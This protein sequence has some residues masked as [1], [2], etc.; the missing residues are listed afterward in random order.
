VLVEG[1]MDFL[2]AW[3]DGVKN[4][5]ATSGTA[6]T[7]EHLK[8]L[9]R[10]ADNLVFCFDSDEAGLKAAE[11]SIDLANALD[12]NVNLLV[13]K[14][15]KD[16]AEV[17]QKS[18]GSLFNF[19]KEAKPAMEFYFARYLGEE[20]RI[21]NAEFRINVGEFKKN[22]RVVLGK[23]K[24]LASAV[25][26]NHWLK[27][28]S[29]RTKIEEKTLAEE[30]EQLKKISKSEFLISK[31]IPNSKFQILNSRRELIAQRLMSLILAKEDLSPQLKDYFEYLPV[32][33][34]K[35]YEGGK[36]DQKL[37]DLMN[38]LSLRSSF[39]TQNIDEEKL[40]KEFRELL[41]HLK[42]EYYKEKKQ[43][44]AKEIKEAERIGDEK[45]LKEALEEF[46]RLSK[47]SHN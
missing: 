32:D 35:I 34:Q 3:Q 2:L 47:L 24:N 14:D 17:V 23:I 38:L 6:L 13:L 43:E 1:Q 29:L 39:E 27:E 42:M 15:Y 26:K 4:V 9:R 31:Q 5:A 36:L 16:P 10:L 22:I 19:I 28:L 41:K 11:R 46:D 40:N 8:T 18:P 30:M 25:E 21:Q 20:L 7:I 44:L 12:F 37:N 33:Y 45:K